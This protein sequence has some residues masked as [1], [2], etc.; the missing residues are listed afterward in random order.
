MSKMAKLQLP[1]QVDIFW[2]GVYNRLDQ[3]KPVK[4]VLSPNSVLL[5]PE[6]DSKRKE[7]YFPDQVASCQ[8]ITDDAQIFPKK[9]AFC[10]F[11]SSKRNLYSFN[12]NVYL[13]LVVFKSR[14]K[15]MKKRSK[16]IILHVNVHHEYDDNLAEANAI[17][18]KMN[19]FL[20]KG[21][22][23]QSNL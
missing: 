5:E 14:V 6:G 7:L 8:V 22:P 1:E 9:L 2:N 23:C 20:K 13:K 18:N 10:C 16:D 11:R 3:S 19:L 12:N 4:L 21:R 17:Q 15:S